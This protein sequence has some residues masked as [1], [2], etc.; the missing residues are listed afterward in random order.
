MRSRLVPC[1]CAGAAAALGCCGAE[2][3][4]A[5][6]EEGGAGDED[7]DADSN[8]LAARAGA[9]TAVGSDEGGALALVR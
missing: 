6:D 9:G 2:G 5:A 3:A 8:P 4:A 7:E 1:C